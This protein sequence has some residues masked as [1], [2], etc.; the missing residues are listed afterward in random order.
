MTEPAFS[1]LDD[2]QES[3]EAWDRIRS[4]VRQFLQLLESDTDADKTIYVYTVTALMEYVMVDPARRLSH[5]LNNLVRLSGKAADIASNVAHGNPDVE[6][7]RPW[8]SEGV[9]DAI[10]NSCV[11]RD[12]Q[13]PGCRPRSQPADRP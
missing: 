3:A 6:S 7:H 13:P 8:T 10:V 11:N 1:L 12:A 2:P 5:V 4:A 9:I